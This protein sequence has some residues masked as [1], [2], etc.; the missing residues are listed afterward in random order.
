MSYI[1]HCFGKSYNQAKE[2]LN[3]N[4]FNIL[5]VNSQ[6]SIISIMN[7]ECYD[8]SVLARQCAFNSIL[9]Y[10]YPNLFN[11]TSK[12]WV[13]TLKIE[14]I[15]NELSHISTEYVLILDGRDTCILKNLDESFIQTFNNMNCDIVFNYQSSC[16]PNNFFKKTKIQHLNAGVCFGKKDDLLQFYQECAKNN[17]QYKHI[18]EYN[19]KPS[20]QYIVKLTA[21]NTN[22]KIHIDNTGQLFY[23]SSQIELIRKVKL[24]N[25]TNQS[26]S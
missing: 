7:K 11:I 14:G 2:W 1:A 15:L 24:W 23:T 10:N 20:E 26:S 6:I 8:E 22:L 3:S 21:L 18:S 19:N 17:Q 13:N 16:Y 25:N 5:Y 12:E 9:L 4:S